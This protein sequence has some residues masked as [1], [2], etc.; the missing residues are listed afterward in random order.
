MVPISINSIKHGPVF[1]AFLRVLPSVNFIIEI[2]E[3]KNVVSCLLA[4]MTKCNS[5]YN[6]I[7]I[8]FYTGLHDR[9]LLTFTQHSTRQMI[10]VSERNRTKTDSWEYIL[11]PLCPLLLRFTTLFLFAD[12]S[13]VHHILSVNLNKRARPER[14]W[15]ILILWKISR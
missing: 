5:E 1:L 3:L 10:E 2:R 4:W 15:E 9:F 6:S 14:S 11:I 7:S 12:Y 13:I 8:N